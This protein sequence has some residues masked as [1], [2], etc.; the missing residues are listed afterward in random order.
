MQ[1][2]IGG[3]DEE[4]EKRA[5]P[6]LLYIPLKPGYHVASQMGITLAQH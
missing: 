3:R 5:P 1:N 2:I 4:S 6:T